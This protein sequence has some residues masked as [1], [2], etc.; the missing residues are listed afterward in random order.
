MNTKGLCDRFE[1][2]GILQIERGL[3]LDNHFETCGSCGQARQKY[4]SL[5]AALPKSAPDVAPRMGWQSRVLQAAAEKEAVRSTFSSAGR[6]T[7]DAWTAIA[8]IGA[9]TAAAF[10]FAPR[11]LPFDVQAETQVT[12]APAMPEM[13]LPSLPESEPESTPAPIAPKASPKQ[14]HSAPVAVTNAPSATAVETPKIAPTIA[15]T[16]EPEVAR[17]SKPQVVRPDK[18]YGFSI[19]YPRAAMEAKVQGDVRAICTIRA[20]GRNTNC[21][22]LKSLP[23]LDEAVL[24]ALTAA[25]TDPIKVNGKAVDNSDHIWHITITLRPP[26]DEPMIGRGMPIVNWSW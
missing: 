20:D 2:E 19:K 15:A 7:T 25:R 18:L 23:F 21:R 26:K 22:I 4:A 12:R 9:L 11:P 6:G 3:P 8:M 5:F 13:A 10:G 16:P 17:S 24:R 14:V 1:R